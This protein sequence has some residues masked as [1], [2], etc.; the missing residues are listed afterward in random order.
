MARHAEHVAKAQQHGEAEEMHGGSRPG[1]ESDAGGEHERRAEPRG[2]RVVAAVDPAPDLQRGE[3]R[4]DGEAGCNDAEPE[5]GKAEF[6]RA[7]GGRDPDDERERLDQRDVGEERDEQAVID[8][9]L[10]G[11]ARAQLLAHQ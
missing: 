4:D 8:V 11:Q 10:W 6:D 2:A 5:D 9:P 1:P 7:V 3:H